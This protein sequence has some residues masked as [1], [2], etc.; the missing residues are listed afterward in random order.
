[1]TTTYDVMVVGGGIVGASTAYALL[2]KGQNVLLIDQF[3]PG[4][5]RGSSHGD[6]RV[7][8]FNYTESIYVEMAM[9]GYPA[10]E[11]LSQAAG[12]PLI[13]KTGMIEYGAVD[14]IPLQESEAQLKKYQIAYEKLSANE[15][16]Q[17]FPQFHFANNANIIY[18]A[19]AAVAFATPAVQ[20]LWRLFREQGG[21]AITG[22]RIAGI[23]VSDEIVTLTA[24]DGASYT[25]AKAVI[26][27]GGWAKQLLATTDLDIPLEVTQEILAYFAP[28]DDSV[29]H[30]IG[31]MPVA[32][33]YHEHLE[34]P[35]YCLPIVDVGGVKMGWHHTGPVMQ[36]DDDRVIPDAVLD[37]MRGWIARFLPQL[38]T[39]PL[40]IH[41]CLY[42][43]TPDYHFILDKHPQYDNIVVA[44][45]FS[46]HGF[47]F[48]PIL[49]ELL[50]DLTLDEAL[51]LSLET[52]AL[53]RF[54]DPSK[55]QRRV[56]A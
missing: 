54:N 56:G 11:R 21:T 47:K 27:A 1:M 40:E 52:F 38:Q 39:E 23:T 15:A 12:I 14:C 5:D 13:Q 45:G 22:K 43:N 26:A 33:D 28:K 18:Q 9:L 16:N 6:G 19:E 29:N 32:I 34:D 53:S 55:I 7:V 30:H 35:F 10:W 3:E 20:A 42:S 31:T 49:G 37:G 2:N 24:T 48:G 8:R 51:P 17:R 44:A 50:A 36:P 46:G 41:T 4:H 25:A